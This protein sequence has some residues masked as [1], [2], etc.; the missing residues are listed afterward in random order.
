MDV[1]QRPIEEFEHW[2]LKSVSTVQYSCGLN[3]STSASRSHTGSKAAY[4]TRPAD[5]QPGNFHHRIG[6]LPLI[7][8]DKTDG[9]TCRSFSATADYMCFI[10]QF[11]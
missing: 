11:L 7:T 9:D 10:V 3:C 6:Y 1:R 8:E 5:R 2:V 4:W